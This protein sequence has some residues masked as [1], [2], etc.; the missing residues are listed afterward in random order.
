MA[1]V[2]A[3]PDYLSGIAFW[4]MGAMWQALVLII[5]VALLA[6]VIWM[7]ARN[8]RIKD[9][10]VRRR[11]LRG[12]VLWS[13]LF[14]SLLLAASITIR[15]EYR[16]LYAPF[17]VM[18]AYFCYQYARLP[19]RAVLRYGALAVICIL[20]VSA[21]GYYKVNES[22]VFFM[23]AEAAADSAYDATMGAYGQGMRDHTM[24][25]ENTRDIHWI[26]GEDL[27]LSPYLGTDYRKIVWVDS[28]AQIDPA[29]IDR[30]KSL[31]FRMDWSQ[32]R[33][34]DVTHEVLGQ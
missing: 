24:Y 19:M 1:W 25:V 6:I 23:S 21:D 32:N 8:L 34:V 11:E 3:G 31:F 22:N 13:V 30:A 28:F 14:V 2:N 12:F 27:F 15:Q 5:F 16:W 9:P 29:T 20:A 17:V 26:F 33:L 18:L 7:L 10:V 4:R